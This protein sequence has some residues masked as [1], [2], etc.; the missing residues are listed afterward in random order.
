MQSRQYALRRTWTAIVALTS[1]ATVSFL[2]PAAAPAAPTSHSPAN[3]LSSTAS[4][5]KSLS[6][7]V[8]WSSAPA[9]STVAIAA[10]AP[11][12]PIQ[13][14][15]T[16]TVSLGPPI[17]LGNGNVTLDWSV[18]CDG[19][20]RLIQGIVG[21]LNSSGVPLG[22]TVDQFTIT[23]SGGGNNITRPCASGILQGAMRVRVTFLSG[24]PLVIEGLFFGP[25]GSAC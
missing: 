18:I 7:N 5:D 17:L 1:L 20:I 11:D 23:G 14:Q 3:T 10:V 2:L 24:T 12:G 13:I 25:A 21:I 4:T 9:W 22:N 16:C 15:T 6:T 8:S 19:Q